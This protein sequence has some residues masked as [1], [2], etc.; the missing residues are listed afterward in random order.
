MRDIGPA[1]SLSKRYIRPAADK[2]QFKAFCAGIRRYGQAKG[3][4]SN[5]DASISEVM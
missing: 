2:R 4:A 5:F 1:C 3:R